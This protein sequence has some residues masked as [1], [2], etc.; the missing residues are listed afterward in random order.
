VHNRNTADGYARVS[1]DGQSVE[2]QIDTLTAAGAVREFSEVLPR[3][4]AAIAD[5]NA[6]NI[7]PTI[8]RIQAAGITSRN[9]IATELNRRGVPTARGGAWTHVSVGNIL[10]R[11]QA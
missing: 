1:T 4:S 5:A 11:V 9:G 3:L 8:E 2:T 6:A 7:L 10:A